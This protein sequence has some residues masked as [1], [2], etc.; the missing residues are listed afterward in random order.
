MFHPAPSNHPGAFVLRPFR[1]VKILETTAP[2]QTEVPREPRM[3]C[4][5]RIS[6]LILTAF[7]SAQAHAAD[8]RSKV[9]QYALAHEAA[10]VGELTALTRL[11]SVAAD[12]AGIAATAHELEA[13]LKQRGVGTHHRDGHPCGRFRLLEDPR[14]QTHGGVLRS[15]RRSAGDALAM[16]LRSLRT[17]DA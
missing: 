6:A 12:P 15:L 16:E 3:Q 14:R 9:Q 1:L 10:I 13:A 8:L 4:I 2:V 11:K 17:R 5:I 7:V